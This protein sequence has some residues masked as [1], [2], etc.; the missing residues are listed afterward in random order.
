MLD[1]DVGPGAQVID[2]I[3]HPPADPAVG[4]AGPEI[5]VLFEVRPENRE[6]ARLPA[7]AGSGAADWEAYRTSDCSCGRW[8]QEA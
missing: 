7:C 5:A 8:R 4:R 3:D 1:A 2:R 6:T